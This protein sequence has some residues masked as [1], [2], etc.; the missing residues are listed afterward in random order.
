[1]LPYSAVKPSE[2][3]LITITIFLCRANQ[4][5]ESIKQKHQQENSK[6]KAMVKK[7]EV[8]TKSLEEALEQKVKENQALTAICDELINKVGE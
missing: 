8:K 3:Y 6:L 4:D 1:M 2:T 5:L 7:L